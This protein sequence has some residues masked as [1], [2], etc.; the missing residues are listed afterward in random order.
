MGV[1]T[2]QRSLDPADHGPIASIDKIARFVTS[3]PVAR[4]IVE[5]DFRV[6]EARACT[7]T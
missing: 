2:V 5:D 4:R 6:S 3:W 7:L 1:W